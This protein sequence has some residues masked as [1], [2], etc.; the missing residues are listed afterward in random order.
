[1]APIVDGLEAEYGN[2]VTFQRL[3]AT[4]EGRDLFQR[5]RLRAHPAYVLLDTEGDV[6]WRM[7]GQVPGE[8]LE[9]AIQ[10]ALE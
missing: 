1:M 8:E 7:V 6:I 2:R 3:D 5:Y 9:Q 4:Q 10:R